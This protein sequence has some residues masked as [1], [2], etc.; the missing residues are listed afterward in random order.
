MCDFMELKNKRVIVTGGAGFIGSNLVDRLAKG[1]TVMVID[2]MHT[3]SD[4]NIS[5]AMESGNVKL[6]KADVTEI[7]KSGFDAEFVFHL[8]FPSSSPMYKE[9]PMLVS[10][11]VAGMIAVLEYTKSHNSHLVFASTSSMYAGQPTPHREDVSLE[12][13]LDYYTE[14]RIYAERLAHLYHRLYGIN[15]IGMRFFSVYGK[16]EKAK[17]GYANLVSQFLWDML[18]DKS[19]VIWG[20]GSQRRDFVYADDVADALIKAAGVNGYDIFNVGTGKNYSLNEL[21]EMLNKKLGKNIQPEYKKM[22]VSNY[23]AETLAYTKKAEEKLGFRAS[24]SLD[25]GLDLMINEY[26]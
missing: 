26:G 9:N 5:E 17:G 21:V 24:I 11:A 25:K 7:Q 1:N 6:M 4:A 3:G 16:H 2:K 10:S 18:E 8:G 13:P 20:D 14:T 22:T 12:I 23:V 15:A 19:P